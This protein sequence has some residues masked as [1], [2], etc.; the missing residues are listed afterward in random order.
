MAVNND[1]AAALTQVQ[2]L[3]TDLLKTDRSFNEG[4]DKRWQRIA[5]IQAEVAVAQA[6]NV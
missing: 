1:V 2:A 3:L 5:A 6:A 4:P